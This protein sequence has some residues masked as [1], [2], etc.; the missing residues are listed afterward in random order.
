M[1]K[2]SLVSVREQSAAFSSAAPSRTQTRCFF[3]YS[4][5]F[6]PVPSAALAGVFEED[7]RAPNMNEQAPLSYGTKTHAATLTDAFAVQKHS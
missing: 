4:A 2:H 1:H 7:G 3:V 5:S 6:F